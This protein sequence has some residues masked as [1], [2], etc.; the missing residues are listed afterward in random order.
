[1]IFILLQAFLL[2]FADDG[3]IACNYK[4][5]KLLIFETSNYDPYTSPSIFLS[6]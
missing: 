3:A 4:E 2:S 5:I 1:M 6:D